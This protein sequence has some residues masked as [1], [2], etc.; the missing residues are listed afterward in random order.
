[1]ERW[2]QRLTC[3]LKSSPEFRGGVGGEWL[4]FGYRQFTG[5]Q[6][7]VHVKNTGI[8]LAGFIATSGCIIRV[9]LSSIY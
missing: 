5:L 4:V 9:T 6:G 3:H 7:E 2:P 1:M 8:T